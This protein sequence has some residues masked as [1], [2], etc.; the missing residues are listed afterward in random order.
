MMKGKERFLVTL[1]VLFLFFSMSIGYAIYGAR[2]N[3]NGV[4]TFS[5][6]GEVTI[7]SAVLTNYENLVNP[8]N[9]VVNGR[10]ISFSLNFNVART[11]EALNDDYFATYQITI[12]N[13]SVFD[14]TF[15]SADFTP[16]L[17]TQNEEDIEISY[18]L[19]EIEMGEVIP[20]KD[21]KTFYLTINMVPNNS[22]ID[23]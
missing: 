9:P 15:S 19:D 2:T 13:D 22:F 20:S 3:V 11:E 18:S 7:S 17:S 1:V 14:Y 23:I 12:S 16:S 10:T 6:N 4:A 8:A 21:S 5:K